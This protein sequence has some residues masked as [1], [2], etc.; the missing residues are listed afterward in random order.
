MGKLLTGQCD[1]GFKTDYL[2]MGTGMRGGGAEFLAG[3]PRCHTLKEQVSATESVCED[4]GSDLFFLHEDENF[5]P[6]DVLQRF[7][8]GEPWNLE[9]TE[10]ESL[11]DENPEISY[12]CPNCEQ[13]K[14][15][16]IESGLWD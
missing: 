13:M 11:F 16:L 2:F 10:D 4:C 15:R 7:D 3:C 5:L 9:D 12:R 14:M 8:V 6:A 1:C